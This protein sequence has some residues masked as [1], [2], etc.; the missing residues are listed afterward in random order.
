MA[1]WWNGIR[2]GFKNH[3]P[4]GFVGSSPTSATNYERMSI[5]IH[6]IRMYIVES[7]S[8]LMV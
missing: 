1:L 2:D 4:Y 6:C 8:A 5:D 3:Y 7:G